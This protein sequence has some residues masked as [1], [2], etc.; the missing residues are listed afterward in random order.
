MNSR[1]L[2]AAL[3]L[4]LALSTA[5][6]QAN[7]FGF[8]GSMNVQAEA[9]LAGFR[10]QLSARFGVPEAKVDTIIKSCDKP[11]DAYMVLRTSEVA[12]QPPERVLTE[13]KA[14]KGQGWGVIAKNLGI[15]PGSPEFHALK[16]GETLGGGGGGGG[17]G[18]EG[19]PGNGH[20]NGHG[21]GK[22][23]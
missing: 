5:P 7:D 16:R 2:G 1:S 11:A 3:A 19:H 18:G 6:A 8:L 20:G 23:K 15:K 17:G 12:K 9:N 13:Y 4:A 10:V 14:N 21:R 22:N